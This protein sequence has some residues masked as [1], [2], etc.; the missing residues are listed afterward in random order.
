MRINNTGN[1]GIGTTNPTTKFVVKGG[2]ISLEGNSGGGFASTNALHL[3]FDTATNIGRVIAL[4]N[5]VSWRQLQI[6]GSVVAINA[7]SGGNVGIGTTSPQTP[8]PNA[9]AGNLDVNDIYSR[10]QGRW[11]SQLTF[12]TIGHIAAQSTCTSICV[13]NNYAGCVTGVLLDSGLATY[14]SR[15]NFACSF[16]PNLAYPAYAMDCVCWK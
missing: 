14:Y 1:V 12:G 8:A 3:I 4:Q 15:G 10:S 7:V 2:G 9:L 11:V 6:D 13:A 5:G 16:N